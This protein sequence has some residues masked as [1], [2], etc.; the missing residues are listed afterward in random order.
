MSLLGRLVL[1]FVQVQVLLMA[2][3]AAPVAWGAEQPDWDNPAVIQINAAPA[4]ATFIPFE[5]R[6]SALVHLDDPKQSSRYLTLAGEWAFHWSPRPAERPQE[7]YQEGYRDV[8]W[9]RVQVPGNWQRQG[10]GLPIY[11]NIN[12][13]F[14]AEDFQVPHEWNPVGSYRRNFELPADWR[15]AENDGGRI[16]LHFEGVDSAFYVWVNG[17]KVGYSQGSRTPAEFDVTTHLRPGHNLIAVEVYR[18][19]DASF[20]EDQDFW[21]LSGIFRDVY[22]W[23]SAPHRLRNFEAVGDY[24]PGSGQGVVT[25]KA[26]VSDQARVEVEILDP[27]HGHTLAQ[28]T[29]VRLDRHRYLGEITLPDIRPW[30]AET[31]ELYPLVLSV[32]D[33]DGTLQEVVAQ[34]MGFRRVEIQSG[35]LMVNGVPIK[36]KGV[37]R[38]EHDPDSGHVISRESMLRDIR[39]MKRHNINAVRTAHY[40]N[41]PEWYRLCDQYGLYVMDEANI[42]THGFGRG[43]ENV[44]NHHPDFKEAHVDR[45]RRMVERDINHPSIIMW[46][47]GNESGDGPNTDACYQWAVQRDP[48]RVVHYENSTYP[49]GSGQATDLN[50]WM[51]LEAKDIDDALAQWPDKPLVLAEYSHAMGN[52]NG[53]LDAYWDKIWQD[54]RIAGAFIWDWMDQGLREP[55]PYGRKDPWGR[56]D[57]LAY[58][59]W[60]EERAAVSHDSNFCMNGL[61]GADGTVYPGLLALK[62]V[63]QPVTVELEAVD[64]P[65]LT[66]TNRFDFLDLSEVCVLHWSL[67]EEG[68]ALRA[69]TLRLPPL[70]PGQ[71]VNV[72]VP[73]DL[74]THFEKETWLNLSFRSRHEQA[75]GERDHEWAWEQFKVGGQWQVPGGRSQRGDI[76]IQETNTNYELAAK[77]WRIVFDKSQM[78]IVHW[79]VGERDLVERGPLPDFWRAPTDNDRGAGLAPA[80]RLRHQHVRQLTRSALWEKAGSD[81]ATDAVEAKLT[82]HGDAVEI[83]FSGK[84]L[85]KRA[86]VSIRY[87]VEASGRLKIDYHFKT[88]EDLPLLPRV[89]TEWILPADFTRMSWYGRGPAETYSDRAMQRVGRYETT[90]LDD[91]VDYAK[92]QENGNKTGV[93]WLHLTGED[94]F[95]LRVFAETTV[96]YTA[97]PF[98]KAQIQSADYSWQLPSPGRVMLNVDYAQLGVGGDNSWGLICLPEYRL[99]VKA[100]RYSYYVEPIMAVTMEP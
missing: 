36:L 57:F 96:N 60:W 76:N 52:S 72:A 84:V 91:W 38:H 5:D 69:G 67:Y 73:I 23:K 7:F 43:P 80:S 63:Q 19:S 75:I 55:V 15:G 68:E 62:Y 70:P 59:G 21:R 8:D 6:E 100:Y 79:K 39:L 42:E 3:L 89:G 83:L 81:W 10:Y 47:V 33:A 66:I 20:L 25:I 14:P 85:N 37:N 64:D 2:G 99:Q 56:E 97:H 93:R 54:P 74:K 77:D 27:S 98:T 82:R 11:T 44:I 71:S 22:L 17:Q 78:T 41:L 31:P 45:M 12:Y 1:G 13:P 65:V 95:G 88:E 26:D 50:S 94:G 46:S 87:T 24:D 61:I 9:D 29:L 16:H 48:S 58:G 92:P 49:G 28:T 40:P 30:S 4:R 53:N 32:R 18:W 35:V 90:V 51:Y 86:E 34:R